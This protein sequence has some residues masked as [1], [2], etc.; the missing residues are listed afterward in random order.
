MNQKHTPRGAKIRMVFC[1]IVGV[2]AI[3]VALNMQDYGAPTW[4]AAVVGI[5]AV[6]IIGMAAKDSQSY[7]E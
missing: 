2:A 4:T 5:I 7:L 6:L 1:T 3:A